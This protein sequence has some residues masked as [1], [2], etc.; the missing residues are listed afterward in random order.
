MSA[1]DFSNVLPFTGEAIEVEAVAIGTGPNAGLPMIRTGSNYAT[2]IM[3]QRPRNLD[4]VVAAVMREAT[5]AGE[6]FYWAWP[7]NDKK[8]KKKK[9]LSGA[10]I[11]LAM[12]VAREWTNVAIPVDYQETTTHDIFTAHF[13]D[14][15]RGFTVSRIWKQSKQ[16]NAGL[17]EW[18]DRAVN[19]TFQAAQSRAI[20]NAVLA[21]VPKWL[22]DQAK[23]V[24][25]ESVLKGITPEKIVAA[26]ETI[27]TT[28]KEL[29]VEESQLVAVVGV[30][31]AQW[32]PAD[33]VVLKGM[34]TQ[35]RDGYASAEELFPA[36]EEPRE[37]KAPPP[38]VAPPPPPVTSAA[39]TP[40]P[41]PPEPPKFKEPDEASRGE[42]KALAAAPPKRGK[43]APLPIA[44]PAPAPKIEAP[45]ISDEGE[46][47]YDT[48][49]PAY[50][51]A[52]NAEAPAAAVKLKKISGMMRERGI[53]PEELAFALGMEVAALSTL[54]A[55]QAEV[56]EGWLVAYKI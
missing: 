16:A 29:G 23:E 56:A 5:L 45:P 30:P 7:V 4:K 32:A 36:L 22:V 43:V 9:M 55:A 11:G 2:A 53:S 31:V 40:P 49:R 51:E 48:P 19:M 1:V 15:E 13:V 52:K 25:Q 46:V 28:M 47:K 26:R 33:I 14:L 35:I 12:C 37:P 10:S 6:A 44:E 42:V 18:G 3:V 17:S 50:P 41:A 34:R 20:R 27:I 54:T 21:G 38:P 8:T 39:P 24:A